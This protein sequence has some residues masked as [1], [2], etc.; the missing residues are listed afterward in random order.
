MIRQSENIIG[1]LNY[2]IL[3]ATWRMQVLVMNGN[4]SNYNKHVSRVLK[5][6]WIFL[7]LEMLNTCY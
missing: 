2:S 6:Q 7:N 4:I 5:M 3:K 1:I